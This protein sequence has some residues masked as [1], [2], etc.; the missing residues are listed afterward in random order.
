M[1]QGITLIFFL[2]LS[3]CGFSQCDQFV[4]QVCSPQLGTFNSEGKR[5]IAVLLP[6]DTAQLG[7]TFYKDHKYRVVVC[8][9]QALGSVRFRLLDRKGAVLFD[10]KQHNNPV[11]WDFNTQLTQNLVIQLIVPNVAANQVAQTG[12]VAV[13]VGFKGID[14]K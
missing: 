8:G 4:Q 11:F 9:Q 6:G 10:S 3:Y 12:C 5:N 13:L 14:A 1:K 7:V 2:L